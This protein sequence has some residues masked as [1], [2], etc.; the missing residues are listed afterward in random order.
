[1]VIGGPFSVSANITGPRS[2]AACIGHGF[3]WTHR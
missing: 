3:R 2:F 1:V